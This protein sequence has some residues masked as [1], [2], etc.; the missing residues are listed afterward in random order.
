[1]SDEK[2]LYIELDRPRI[3]DF[4]KRLGKEDLLYINRLV[5]DRLTLLDQIKTSEKMTGFHCGERV[6][7][8]TSDG[9]KIIGKVAKL[10]KVT[11]T[12]VTSDGHRWK[13]SPGFLRSLE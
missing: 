9:R 10:N 2:D 12:V 3:E 4:I 6:S 7:F 11:I 5:I 1:M 8:S 13:V